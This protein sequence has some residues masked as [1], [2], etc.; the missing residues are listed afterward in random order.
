MWSRT[1]LTIDDVDCAQIYDGFSMLA[2]LWLEAL[3]V[4][5]TGEAGDFISGGEKIALDGDLPMNTHGGQL[6][7]GRLHGFGFIH[8]AVTQLRG[9]GGARQIARQPEVAVATNGY[10]SAGTILLT[11]GIR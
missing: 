9:D 1:E 2:I 10:G 4:C 3:G 6:S 11:R 5:G 8:E 7:A